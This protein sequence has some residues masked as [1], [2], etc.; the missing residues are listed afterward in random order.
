VERKEGPTVT[1][2]DNDQLTG[3]AEPLRNLS[4][5]SARCRVR[6]WFGQH[7]IADYTAPPQLAQR[8]AAA[9]QRRFAGLQV[10][11]DSCDL[12]DRHL[13]T[14]HWWEVVPR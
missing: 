7:A 9:I 2:D 10:T 8:Y 11:I 5:A 3:A 14:E 6:L 1:A 12:G 13:P 4:T